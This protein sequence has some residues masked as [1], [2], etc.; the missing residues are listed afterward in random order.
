M[1]YSGQFYDGAVSKPWKVVVSIDSSGIYIVKEEAPNET[2]VWS[3]STV[4]R[5]EKQ[6]DKV[7]IHYGD[8]FPFLLLSISSTEC[9]ADLNRFAGGYSFMKTPHQWFE[10]LGVSAYAGALGVIVG[11]VLLVHFVLIPSIQTVVVN[12]ISVEYEKSLSVQYLTL[13]KET[14]EIDSLKSIQLANF[15][16]ELNIESKY[17]V[18]AF[19]VKSDMV[20]AMALPGGYMVVYTG[21]LDKMERSEELVALVGHELGHVEKKH[22]LKQLVKGLSKGYLLELLVGNSNALLEGVGGVVSM[23][24]QMAYSRD[25]EREADEFGYQ[26]LENNKLDPQ[27]MVQ[28]FEVLQA[29][30]GKVEKYSRF[31]SMISTHPLTS[32]RISDTKKRIEEK[33]Y[34]FDINPKLDAIF[35]DLKE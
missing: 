14:E 22:S 30:T 18:E 2:I 23:F 17:E 4:K 15:I 35:S 21:I 5:I 11:F 9:I 6:R 1:S 16:D 8:K 20:N 3:F 7:L 10:N 26:V 34:E 28:L 27:G 32:D 25:A 13:L 24:D 29:E 19:V 33:P 12:N 31:V